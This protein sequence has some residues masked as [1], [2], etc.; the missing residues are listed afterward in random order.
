ML[1]PESGDEVSEP[2][3][4]RRI[5]RFVEHPLTNLVKSLTLLLIGFSDVGV[6]VGEDVSK[7]HLRVGH[8]LLLIGFFGLLA[9]VPYLLDSLE[10]GGR[11]LVMKEQRRPK[12]KPAKGEA[13]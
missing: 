3:L 10:A 4:S 1:E 12:E 9:S 5:R 11:F 6:R 2:R 7:W 13:S 8:G